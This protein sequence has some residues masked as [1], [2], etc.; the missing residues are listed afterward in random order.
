VH[1]YNINAMDMR[2]ISEA[3]R[4]NP[5]ALADALRFTGRMGHLVR[6]N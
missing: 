6:V 5:G 2:S 3:L 4:R 1:Q